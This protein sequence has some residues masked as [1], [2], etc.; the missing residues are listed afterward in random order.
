MVG[1]SRVTGKQFVNGGARDE[2]AATD[3]DGVHFAAVDRSAE[4][5]SVDAEAER[6][7]SD[8]EGLTPLSNIGQFETRHG[9]S[10]PRS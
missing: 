3:A 7:L 2:P 4:T 6:C 8:R 9:N 5:G 10:R 1:T